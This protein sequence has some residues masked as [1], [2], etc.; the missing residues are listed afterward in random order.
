MAMERLLLNHPDVDA[1]FAASDLMAAA[2]IGVLH[3]AG[4]R[5]PEDIAVVGFDD[6]P[7]ALSTRPQ[8]STIRQPIEQLGHEA[9]SMLMREMQEPGRAPDQLVLATELVVRESTIGVSA[10]RAAH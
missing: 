5:I 7:T 6:S 4:K 2:A 10:V 3:Q 1:V 9:I 8:L